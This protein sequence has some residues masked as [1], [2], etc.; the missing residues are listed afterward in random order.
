MIERQIESPYLMPLD[1]VVKRRVEQPI[2]NPRA[3]IRRRYPSHL[4]A[5]MCIVL[6]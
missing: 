1:L 4:R 5:L 6:A 2:G 3:E